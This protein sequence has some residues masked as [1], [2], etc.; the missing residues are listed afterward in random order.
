MNKSQELW[1]AKEVKSIVETYQIIQ[2]VNLDELEA[3]KA[4]YHPDAE[5]VVISGNSEYNDEGYSV[6]LQFE[7]YNPD[8]SKSI[9]PDFGDDWKKQ[10]DYYD[11]QS[12]LYQGGE[13]GDSF[14]PPSIK[15]F[16]NLKA[17]SPA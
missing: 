4:K 8:G 5:Y 13:I 14:S 11:E 3:F 12:S 15:Y 17:V 6:Q 9:G 1:D 7:F 16:F 2:Y 10:D